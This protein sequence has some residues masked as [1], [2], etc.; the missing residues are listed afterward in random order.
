MKIL[1]EI[2]NLG[3]GHIDPKSRAGIFRYIESIL[4]QLSLRDDICLNFTS[5]TNFY[6]A[7]FTQQYLA[8][9]KKEWAGKFID[10][11]KN[12]LVLKSLYLEVLESIRKNESRSL[13]SRA[14]RK[15]QALFLD[16]LTSLA[17]PPDINEDFDIYHSFYH[18]FPTQ[19]QIN[20]QVRII[21]IYDMIPFIL[22]EYFNKGFEKQFA[23]ILRN[24]EIRKDW[25]I[26]ISESTKKDFCAYSKMPE[27]RVFI[28]PL[29]ANPKFY[30]K[31]NSSVIKDTCQKYQIPEGQYILGLSTLEPRKNTVFLIECFY[32]LLLENI[33]PDTYLVLAGA[34]GWLFHDIFH[35]AETHPN[36]LNRIIFTGYIQDE[37]LSAIYS[38]ATCFVYPSFYEGFGLPPLEAMQCGVPVITSNT[39]SLPEVVGDA[40]ILI[41]PKDE[42]Q[43]CQ[44]MFNMLNDSNLRTTLSQKGLERAK[45]FSWKKCADQTVEIYQ[46]ILDSK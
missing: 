41:D 13:F 8:T 18:P 11:Y 1:Y 12:R 46:K 28:T 30:P 32:R 7:I 31:L 4:D 15:S 38:G 36:L 29:A 27:E 24:L 34:K 26:C 14:K 43:L 33:L 23:E 44:A 35:T 22:P 39:S 17:N 5:H 40:G 6:N 42:D 37:D 16:F 9:E 3:L 10:S 25:C 2:S 20:T 21:T 19:P 45:Q